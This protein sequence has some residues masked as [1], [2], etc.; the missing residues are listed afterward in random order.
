MKYVSRSVFRIIQLTDSALNEAIL[1]QV[2]HYLQI[3]RNVILHSTVCDFHIFKHLQHSVFEIDHISNIIKAI[4][5]NYANARLGYL[6][7]RTLQAKKEQRP[8]NVPNN[9]ADF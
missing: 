8:S 7:K 1:K 9:K 5:R 6:S 4:S 2:D 3:L